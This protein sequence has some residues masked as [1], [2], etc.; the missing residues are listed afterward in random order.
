LGG[1]GWWGATLSS[2]LSLLTK[3]KK[4]GGRRPA[5]WERGKKKGKRGFPS[6]KQT[7]LQFLAP[8]EKKGDG[9]LNVMFRRSQG[10]EKEKKEKMVRFAGREKLIPSLHF[11]I[12]GKEGGEKGARNVAGNSEKER[13]KKK[14]RGRSAGMT[15]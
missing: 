10:R 13:K 12:Q 8:K 15:A 3:K 4:N 2:F 7:S 9:P 6:K 14:K 1:G 11:P 5:K